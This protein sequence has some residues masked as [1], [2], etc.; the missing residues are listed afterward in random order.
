MPDLRFAAPKERRVA[1]VTGGGR[2]IGRACALRIAGEGRD[3]VIAEVG[4]FGA[5]V[6]PEVEALGQ[7]AL[8]VRT[9]V[10]DEAS[11]RR[12]AAQTIEAFG[13]LDILVCCAGIL[14]LEAPFLE[15]SAAQFDRVMRIN[16]YGVYHAHQAAIPHML[17]RGWGRCVTI[18]SGARHAATN[19][20]PYGVSKGA[21]YSFIGALGNAYPKQGVFVNGVEPGRALTQM[22]VPRFSPEFLANPGN[23]IGRYADPEEIAEVVE[24][25]CSERNTYTTGSVWSVKGGTG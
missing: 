18:T 20:V 1:V 14:G 11:V 12:M 2:G 8:F 22:V 17:A 13:R 25:L 15:Q 19:Q 23:P 4:D 16:V 24:F 21:V 10:T 6:V 3:I 9:D 7:R 5:E